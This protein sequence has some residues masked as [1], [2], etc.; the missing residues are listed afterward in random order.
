MIYQWKTGTR[1]KVDAEVAAQVMNGLAA[2]NN[3]IAKALVDV[4]RPEDAPLHKEFEWD[5][6]IAAERWR[7]QQGRVMIASIHVITDSS[8]K[9][10]PVRA[11]F[12][13]EEK[14]SNYEPIELIIQDEE[15]TGRLFQQALKE[16]T[17]FREK[18]KTLKAF[19]KLFDDITEIEQQNFLEDKGA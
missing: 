16:L 9:Q 7:E 10:D 18:Y 1:Y 13:I 8:V 17:A 14:Q 5:D 3:L 19:R 6:G 4:S 11:Y 15:K 12:H 2:E